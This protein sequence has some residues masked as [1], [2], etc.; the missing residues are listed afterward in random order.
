MEF[1][2]KEECERGKVQESLHEPQPMLSKG[3]PVN[4]SR[5][6]PKLFRCLPFSLLPF[7]FSLQPLSRPAAKALLTGVFRLARPATR[8]VAAPPSNS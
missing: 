8:A 5:R 7:T 4:G 1:K 3:I 6:F 2:A